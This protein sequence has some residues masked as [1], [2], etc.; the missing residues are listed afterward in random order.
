MIVSEVGRTTSGSSSSLPPPWVTTAVSGAKPST[1][2]ASRG[3]EALRDEQREV[4]VLVAGVLEHL[5]ERALHLLPDGVAVRPDDHAAAHRA[6]VGQLG[7]GD[8]LVVPGT[9]ISGAGGERLRCQPFPLHRPVPGCDR[10][11]HAVWPSSTT[12]FP[13]TASCP[14]PEIPKHHLAPGPFVGSNHDRNRGLPGIGQL[15]LLAESLGDQAHIRP[16]GPRRALVSQG[17]H[18]TADPLR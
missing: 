18:V 3:Q 7:P 4:G 13:A 9:E 11:N 17:K 1:C 15:E 16:E 14:F 2:S 8:Q 5:V 6:V 12:P 10:V